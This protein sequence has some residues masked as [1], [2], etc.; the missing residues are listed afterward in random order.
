MFNTSENR[1]PLGRFIELHICCLVSLLLPHFILIA[2]YF[3]PHYPTWIV[4]VFSYPIFLFISY[5]PLRGLFLLH[6]WNL[7][8]GSYVT[9]V[10]IRQ[11]IEAFHKGDPYEG[12]L[13]KCNEYGTR[14][15]LTVICLDG[16]EL[17]VCPKEIQSVTKSDLHLP[18]LLTCDIFLLREYGQYLAK[19][20]EK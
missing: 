13:V 14:I 10:H 6:W 7:K 12:I 19:G 8:I 11:T 15:T 18:E 4:F 20:K 5:F 16:R 2:S 9:G 3:H 1:I 17:V